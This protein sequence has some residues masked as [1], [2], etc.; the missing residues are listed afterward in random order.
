MDSTYNDVEVI[1]KNAQSQLDDNQF[2]T[3]A[4][5]M[6][7]VAEA[8]AMFYYEKWNAA[9]KY[10]EVIKKSKKHNAKETMNLHSYIVALRFKVNANE[11][12]FKRNL[13]IFLTLAKAYGNEGSHYGGR[14]EK[15]EIEFLILYYRNYIREHLLAD[16]DRETKKEARYKDVTSDFA[17]KRVLLY[18]LAA[19]QYASARIDVEDIPT[20]C[21]TDNQE[22][23]EQFQITVDRE[24][25]ASF[26]AANDLYLSVDLS[27]SSELPPIKGIGPESSSWEKFRIYKIGNSFAIKAVC[28]QK[29]VTSRIDWD[30][31]PLLASCDKADFWEMFDIKI[32]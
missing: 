6:R 18:S 26:K 13:L 16:C 30:N 1:V 15:A 4:N 20:Y 17:D 12:G 31:N 5:H 19:E 11:E 32:I 28:N 7:Q 23:W 8:V 3:A 24:G 22:E 9:E 10:K 2:G 21:N 25:Q 29:W 27:D 14:V